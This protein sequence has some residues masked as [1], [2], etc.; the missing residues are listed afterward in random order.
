MKNYEQ[1]VKDYKDK[2]KF[3]QHLKEIIADLGYGDSIKLTSV[4]SNGYFQT[5]TLTNSLFFKE[6]LV[7]YLEGYIGSQEVLLSDSKEKI[8]KMEETFKNLHNKP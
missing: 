1:F 7:D 4:K 3:V 6:G 2:K 5:E 8:S